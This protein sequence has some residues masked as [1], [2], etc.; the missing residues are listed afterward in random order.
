MTTTATAATAAT[1]VRL[2]IVMMALGMAATL[3]HA[4]TECQSTFYANSGT[5]A[6]IAFCITANGN[7]AMLQ[8]GV[9]QIGDGAEGYALCGGGVDY[10]DLGAYGDSGN[11]AAATVVQPKG[12]N[13]FPLSVVR[14][15]LDGRATL[16]QAF[17]LGS[18]GRSVHVKMT[19]ATGP[20][21]VRRAYRY[22][23]VGDGGGYG[24]HGMRSAFVWSSGGLGL[25]AAPALTPQVA[26][27][28]DAAG[29]PADACVPQAAPSLPYHGDAVTLL[30][31]EVG[32]GRKATVSFDYVPIR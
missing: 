12:A 6:A 29:Q 17:T 31:W 11:W 23:H 25:M 9:M 8:A 2:T 20:G 3:A 21:M 18:G 24:D 22:A 13:T 4:T 32:N 1:A 5:Q 19:V 14:A 27:G 15:T 16:T 26:A 28:L 7:V 30:A 10:W